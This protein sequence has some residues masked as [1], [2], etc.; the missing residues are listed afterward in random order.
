MARYNNIFKAFNTVFP[1]ADFVYILQQ[2]EYSSL[3]LVRWLPRFFFRRNIQVRD[4]LVWTARAIISTA[5]SATLWLGVMLGGLAAAQTS[6]AKLLLLLIAPLLIPLF[7]LIVNSALSLVEEFPRKRVRQQAALRVAQN[8]ELKVIV[9]AGSYGKT[10]TKNFIN[11]LVKYSHRTQMIPGNIN[12]PSGIANWLLANLRPD[13]EL[14]VA[15]VD[16]YR[17]GEIAQS[18]DIL[19][20]DIAV[21]TNIGDQHLERFA[22]PNDLKTALT[23]VFT[24]SK[25]TAVR[26]TT[27][28]T[29][30]QIQLDITSPIL[31]TPDITNK[32]LRYGNMKIDTEN[33]SESNLTNLALALEVANSLHIPD[34]IVRD[35]V[36]KLELPERRQ[37][38]TTIF[39][40]E[41]IDD[42]Y[43][44]SFSTAKAGIETAR[45]LADKVKKKLLVITAGIPE[46][47]PEDRDNNRL[48]G[49]LLDQTAD[50]T[51]VLKSYLAP[52]I[53]AGF[54][55]KKNFTVSKSLQTFLEA[56]TQNFK[57]DEWFLLFQPE[58]N[59]LYY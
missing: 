14:L 46:L 44:I 51:I 50:H 21:L 27:E 20:A 7:V 40:Y 12:T 11:Q 54:G 25:P 6:A 41:G 35:T 26:I 31:T 29:K 59:D 57:R 18:C 52:E 48:L 22:S 10:T 2:E 24:H 47:A 43:N 3:R 13:T 56:G 15:E 1:F 4:H 37:Q 17:I 33:L 58:L 30:L 19:N 36:P 9:I 5:G 23:E 16:A 55:T 42:S 39:G 32:D 53:L 49:E 45:G 28:H 38:Q 34:N 8:L